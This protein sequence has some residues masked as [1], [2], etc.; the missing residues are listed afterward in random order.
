MNPSLLS[1]EWVEAQR[2]RIYR[3]TPE[4]RIQTRDAAVAFVNELGF[5]FF[6]P[7]KGVECAS[8][9][10]AIAGRVRD[11]PNEHDDPDINKCWGW[12]DELLGARAWFY[13]KL[14]RRRATLVSLDLL[15][16]FYALSENY[17]DYATDYLE[18]YAR[19]E[20]TAEARGIY[21]A[22]LHKG[23]LG[24]VRLRRA[25]NLAAE[26]AKSRFDRALVEL[27][28]GLKVLPVGVTQEGA[29]DYAFIYDIVARHY[30]DLPERARPIARADARQTLIRHYVDNSVAVS[31]QQVAQLFHVLKWTPR[32]LDRALAALE[33]A[34]AIREMT[35]GGMAGPQ[36]VSVKALE[37][38]TSGAS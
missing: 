38:L 25:A 10:H 19:G 4:R 32:E 30:P 37:A 2:A 13:A 7:I 11:V 31:R 12:K 28:A 24:T 26:S 21:E 17:G 29:W 22:L 16:A 35:I 14:L 33:E 1:A 15:P 18:E 34:G 3:R 5:V 27:Q 8:L 6:W 20:M 9:F 23:P 36:W